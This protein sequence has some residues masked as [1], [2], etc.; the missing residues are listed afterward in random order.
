[1]RNMTFAVLIFVASLTAHAHPLVIGD[2]DGGSRPNTMADVLAR[3]EKIAAYLPV[4]DGLSRFNH[5]HLETT[6]NVEKALRTHRFEDPAF[7][8]PLAVQ[9]ANLYFDAV[10]AYFAPGQRPPGAWLPLFRNRL[11]GDRFLEAQFDV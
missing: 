2:P 3:M 7:M 5:L 9:F 8:D 4:D 10:S 6:R 1:M 11:R